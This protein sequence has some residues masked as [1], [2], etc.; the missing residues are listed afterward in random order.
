MEIVWNSIRQDAWQQKLPTGACALQQ[1]WRFGAAVAN[2][3][4]AVLRA[5]VSLNGEPIALAQVICRNFV[6]GVGLAY[7]PRGPIWCAPLNSAQKRAVLRLIRRSL[8]QPG[9]H[10]MICVPEDPQPG[11]LPLMTPVHMAELPLTTA[12]EMR[13]AM[14]GKWR[15]RLAHAE[16]AGIDVYATRPDFA[17]IRWLIA[18]DT[19]Q[20]RARR[21][22]AL[23]PA[24]LRAWSNGNDSGLRLY[25]A[26]LG[27]ESLAAM[28]FLDHA[29]GVT[30]QIG[31]TS[32]AGRAGSAHNLILWRA[33]LDFAAEERARLDLG[34]V[35]TVNAPGLARFKIG[36]GGKVRGLGSS[37]LVLPEFPHVSRGLN[38]GCSLVSIGR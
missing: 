22:R 28:L 2:M 23:P 32:E 14:H 10:F 3:G 12:P 4:R 16:A 26:Q 38:A 6:G 30:Y 29:P 11:L 27:G 13:K 35:D 37:G 34:T 21:Y 7:L 19:A 20:Q 8:P 24:F 31:W 15:N 33:M 18:K 1:S 36:A 5:E 25:T 9:P 17:D